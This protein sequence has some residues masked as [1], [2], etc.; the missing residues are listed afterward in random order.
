LEHMARIA[1]FW[2]SLMLRGG[3]CHGDPLLAHL[4]HSGIEPS[5]IDRRLLLFIAEE[6]HTV[7]PLRAHLVKALGETDPGAVKTATRE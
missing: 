2:F 4:R 6:P 1:N 7:A 3:R 5:R